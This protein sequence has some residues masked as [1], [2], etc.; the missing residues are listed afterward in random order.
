MVK[1]TSCRCYIYIWAEMGVYNLKW[2]RILDSM[3]PSNG[4]FTTDENVI[5]INIFIC[6][7][8]TRNGLGMPF[9]KVMVIN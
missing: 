9:I 1:L 4:E 8:M 5:I 3:T 6:S 2:G 7:R